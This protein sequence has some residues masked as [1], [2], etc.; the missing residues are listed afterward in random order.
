M[1][2]KRTDLLNRK[3][4]WHIDKKILG[5]RICESTRRRTSEFSRT[6]ENSISV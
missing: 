6:F 4:I 1:E 5:Q 3:G 2:R